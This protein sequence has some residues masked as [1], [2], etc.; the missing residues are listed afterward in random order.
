[1]EEALPG[2]FDF[3]EKAK[4]KLDYNATGALIDFQDRVCFK[5]SAARRF[6]KQLEELDRKTGGLGNQSREEVDLNLDCFL[7]ELVGSLDPLLQ[8]INLVFIRSLKPNKVNIKQITQCLPDINKL[9]EKISNI[10][11]DEKGWFWILREYRN[12][13]AHR[14]V[15]NW[16]FDATLGT[17][18]EGRD[19]WL[20]KLPLDVDSGRADEKILEYCQN[21]I[22]R[23]KSLLSELY[24]ICATEAEKI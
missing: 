17:G 5:L 22:E 13:S 3:R 24:D 8:Q 12:H 4:T 9:R 18:K 20:R 11:N 21:S 19:V 1:M 6:L 14:R 2:G 7:Y 15:I 10:D 16:H 23:M